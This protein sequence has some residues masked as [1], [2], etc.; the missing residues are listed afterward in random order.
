MSHG[1][2]QYTQPEINNVDSLTANM[3]DLNLELKQKNRQLKE[4]QEERDRILSNISHDLRAPLY[5]VRSAVDRLSSGAAS[6]KE[7]TH[8]IGIIDR[9]TAFLEQLIEDLYLLQRL[10]QPEFSLV[11]TPLL[12][13]PFLEEYFI[14]LQINGSLRQIELC[15]PEDKNLLVNLDANYFI[16]V[17]DNLFSNA[18]RHTKAQDKI[19]LAC[20][21]ENGRILILLEDTGEGI[22]PEDLPHI[23]ERT[24]T[25]SQAR[26]PDEGRRGLGL[27]IAK[28]IVEKHNAYISCES[29]L[30]RGTAFKISLPEAAGG[31]AYIKKDATT[32]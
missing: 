17:L 16:R 12:I 30:C 3:I 26:T 24:Y 5:A 23:F 31:W 29:S 25:A 6:Q 27:F 20:R 8:L 13:A 32:P 19:R 21:Y 10:E 9:R 1:H 4:I 18:V 11:M 2:N 15:L 14:S 28:S 22:A 7:I